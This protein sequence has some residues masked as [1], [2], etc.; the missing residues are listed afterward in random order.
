[1]S[2]EPKP[3]TECRPTERVP[4]TGFVVT[5]TKLT[6]PPFFF[7]TF[8]GVLSCLS[9]AHLPHG[10]ETTMGTTAHNIWRP[11]GSSFLKSRLS[12]CQKTFVPF[13][14][15]PTV[16]SFVQPRS[17][18]SLFLCHFFTPFLPPSTHRMI[19]LHHPSYHYRHHHYEIEVTSHGGQ[20]SKTK[21]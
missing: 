15:L 4:P 7:L 6:P 2:T 8:L 11:R 17:H 5:S 9:R 3:F 21:T 16:T 13:L 18:S 19:N 10:N 12:F 1:M 14:R 20:I